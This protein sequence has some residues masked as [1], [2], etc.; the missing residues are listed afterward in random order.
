[1]KHEH[2]FILLKLL[3]MA[4][5]KTLLSM[6]LNALSIEGNSTNNLLLIFVQTK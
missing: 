1:M 2:I 3:D 4:F 6:S 5:D